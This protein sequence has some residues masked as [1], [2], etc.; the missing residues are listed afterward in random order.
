[1]ERLTE[2]E[3]AYYRSYPQQTYGKIIGGFFFVLATILFFKSAYGVLFE[4][5]IFVDC[6]DDVSG[7]ILVFAGLFIFFL[8]ILMMD[9]QIVLFWTGHYFV[10]LFDNRIVAYNMWMRPRTI[11]Y[12]DVVEFRVMK[13]VSGMLVLTST[14]K[15]LRLIS[16]IQHLG[17]CIENIQK[18]AVNLKKINFGGKDKIPNFWNFESDWPVKYGNRN[19]E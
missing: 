1:M 10:K 17:E 12:E 7:G 4:S 2:E 6:C 15:T 11:R 14:G 13:F 19:V 5:K 9:Y 8:S 3:F 16:G 18:R